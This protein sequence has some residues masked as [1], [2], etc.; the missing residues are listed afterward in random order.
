M[1]CIHFKLF[2]I[3][4]EKFAC[5]SDFNKNTNARKIILKLTEQINKF[6]RCNLLRIFV[7]VFHGFYCDG[8]KMAIDFAWF[9]MYI[10]RFELHSRTN[11]IIKP[12]KRFIL[13]RRVWWIIVMS[14]ASFQNQ[15]NRL[16]YLK[17]LWRC[18]T[19]VI[20]RDLAFI[21]GQNNQMI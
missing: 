7:Q 15:L 11:F 10:L 8:L 17:I 2:V 9:F 1:S 4:C 3:Q 12:A 21:S 16:K 14:I 20:K 19:T 13:H 18:Q 5:F 6:R